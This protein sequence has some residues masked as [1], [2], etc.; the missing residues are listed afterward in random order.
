MINDEWHYCGGDNQHHQNHFDLY[1]KS[2]EN[3]EQSKKLINVFV[4]IVS[5]KRYINKDNTCILVLGNCCIKHFLPE[6]KSRR[7]CQY[8]KIE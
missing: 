1:N 8:I 3:F 5:K 2:Y 6:G 4:S 7:T